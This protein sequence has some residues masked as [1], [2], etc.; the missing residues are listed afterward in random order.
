MKLL[1]RFRRRRGYSSA[2]LA[3]FALAWLQMALTPC[4]M[5]ADLAESQLAAG[6]PAAV[7]L[8]HGEKAAQGAAEGLVSPDCDYCPSE[9]VG[10]PCPE[11]SGDCAYLHDPGIDKRDALQSQLER[12]STHAALLDPSAFGLL[13]VLREPSTPEAS[14]KAPPAPHRPL[15]LENCTQ[16]R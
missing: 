9:E 13:R 11:A 4:L 6:A 5:A 12:L 7:H 15:I 16:L 1:Q 8:S 10:S 14:I 3:A 2:S